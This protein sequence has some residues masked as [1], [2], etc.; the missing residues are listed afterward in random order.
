MAYL[1]DASV[2][3]SDPPPSA[4]SSNPPAAAFGRGNVEALAKATQKFVD[5]ANKREELSNVGMS[6]RANVPQVRV[7][8]DRDKAKTLGVSIG[9]VSPGNGRS[10]S[11]LTR[12]YVDLSNQTD[13]R[14][15]LLQCGVGTRL[16]SSLVENHRN[17]HKH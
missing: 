7:A 16:P 11:L 2:R 15:P 5:A 3:S 9:L 13:C 14:V 1:S 17:L 10:A 8:V 6:Y 4:V 12:S